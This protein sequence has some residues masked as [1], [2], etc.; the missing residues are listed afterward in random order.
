MHVMYVI[1]ILIGLFDPVGYSTGSLAH[2]VTIPFLTVNDVTLIVAGKKTYTHI[3]E[4]LIFSAEVC[5]YEISMKP[6]FL[7]SENRSCNEKEILNM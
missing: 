6:W 7:T 3:R 4:K 1:E 5:L 2:Q